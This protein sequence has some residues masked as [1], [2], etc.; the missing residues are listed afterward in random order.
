MR[1]PCPRAVLAVVVV[2]AR[3]AAAAC[4][5]RRRPTASTAA[6]QRATTPLP[7]APDTITIGYQA[8]PNGDLVVKHEGW[9]EEAFPDTRSS[10]SCS[11]R[12]ARSTRRSS[13]GSIDFGL[14]G[15]SP[16]SR[17]LAQPIEYQVPWIHD[18][19][20]KAE[21]LVVVT[22]IASIDDLKGKTIATPFASTAHYSLLAALEDAGLPETDV[23]IIDAEPD[24]IY[25]AWT[26][27]HI[28]GAY[29]WNPNL[30]KLVDE[31]GK[32]LVDSA[33]AGGEGQDHLRPRGRDQRVRREV[34]RRRG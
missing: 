11:T 18:V 29:V 1:C 15:S 30:A 27:K 25:A 10:G 33:A 8:I 21:A 24:A 7:P 6:A 5:R 2:A 31:G 26:A 32:V 9:L 16:V 19:I 28:D 23:K 17:A 34:P 4:G 14:A 22:D 20:G 13:A 3:G 12:A